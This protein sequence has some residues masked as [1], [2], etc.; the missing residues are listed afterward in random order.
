MT[1][2]TV[3]PKR[4][5]LALRPPG[6]LSSDELS[7]EIA[8]LEY[9]CLS[10]IERTFKRAVLDLDYRAAVVAGVGKRREKGAP[11][12]IAKSRQFWRMKLQWRCEDAHLI[13][14]VPQNLCV[15]EMHVENA[16]FELMNCPDRIHKLPDK[17]R[18]VEVEAEAF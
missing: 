16:V 17:M 15:L 4:V 10:R 5:P 1:A 9:G 13:E 7:E 12:D 11:A 3:A 14:L 18:R 8:A 2:A 6:K